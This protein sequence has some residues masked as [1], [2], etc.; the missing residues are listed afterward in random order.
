MLVADIVD[1][2]VSYTHLTWFWFVELLYN[3][4]STDLENL[5]IL[6][7]KSENSCWNIVHSP[8]KL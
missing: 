4:M 8:L 5:E 7:K 3:I 1:D 2:A 6:F